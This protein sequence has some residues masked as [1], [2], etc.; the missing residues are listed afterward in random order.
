M[1]L[2]LSR[3][4]PRP[5]GKV[6]TLKDA[7]RLYEAQPPRIQK[8]PEWDT[9]F[10]Q[11]ALAAASPDGLWMELAEIAVRVVVRHQEKEKQP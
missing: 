6:R 11:V 2:N 8:R 7:A 9:M 5:I 10:R 4:F 1:R 3:R